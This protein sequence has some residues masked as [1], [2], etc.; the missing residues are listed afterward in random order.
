MSTFVAGTLGVG[1]GMEEAVKTSQGEN[2]SEW[3]SV[4]VVD[5]MSK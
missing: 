5:F 1:E 4:H 2:L 3:L